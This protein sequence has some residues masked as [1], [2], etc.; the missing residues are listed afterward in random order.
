M[1]EPIS[2]DAP[3]I[4]TL[5]DRAGLSFAPAALP[6]GTVLVIVLLECHIEEIMRHCS[7]FRS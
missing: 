6:M 4:N 7:K 3:T 5:P 1:A 2:P